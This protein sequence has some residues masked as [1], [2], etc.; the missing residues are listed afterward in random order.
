[1]QPLPTHIVQSF[2]L[3]FWRE[4]SQ[5]A[6]NQWRGTIWHEQQSPNEKPKPVAGPEEAFEIIRQALDL[7]PG[8]DSAKGLPRGSHLPEWLRNCARAG[9]RLSALVRR[10]R[11]RDPDREPAPPSLHS[12]GPMGQQRKSNQ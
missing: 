10:F 11:G 4:P 2:G 1:M 9:A 7:S 5:A 6:P 12:R 3:R 8:R